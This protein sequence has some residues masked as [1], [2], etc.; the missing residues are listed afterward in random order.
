MLWRYE[1]FYY[2]S[3]HGWVRGDRLCEA[4]EPPCGLVCVRIHRHG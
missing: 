3:E 2:E 1:E 4:D